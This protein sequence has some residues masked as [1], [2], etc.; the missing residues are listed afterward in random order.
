MC[1]FTLSRACHEACTQRVPATTEEGNPEVVD[2]RRYPWS[3]KPRPS[4]DDVTVVADVL[5]R[6]VAI[7]LPEGTHSMCYSQVLVLLLFLPQFRRGLLVALR[8]L[9]HWLLRGRTRR[10]VYCRRSAR[11][12]VV[13]GLDP[14]G[15]AQPG[16]RRR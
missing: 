8:L 15:L 6:A 10:R 4:V 1:L 5:V 13:R 2:D 16:R 7:A 11:R 3:P 14:A 9:H 12:S